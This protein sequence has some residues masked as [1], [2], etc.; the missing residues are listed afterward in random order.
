[1]K[2]EP[3]FGSGTDSSSEQNFIGTKTTA[4]AGKNL[5]ENVASNE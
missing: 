2:G 5:K 3:K 1:M 4:L